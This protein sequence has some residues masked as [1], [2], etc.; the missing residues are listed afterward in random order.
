MQL[1]NALFIGTHDAHVIARKHLQCPIKITRHWRCSNKACGFC[2]AVAGKHFRLCL[3]RFANGFVVKFGT[4]QKN[5]V[6]FSY[7]TISIMFEQISQDLIH[8][9]NMGNT[10]TEH[11]VQN[12]LRLIALVYDKGVAA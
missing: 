11:I 3:Q 7:D 1:P 12:A 5:A 8:N 6:I 9:R 4:A 10:K 2:H